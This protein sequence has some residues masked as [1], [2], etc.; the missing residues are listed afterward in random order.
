MGVPASSSC[1]AI[2]MICDIQKTENRPK[3]RIPLQWGST[4]SG[5]SVFC[6]SDIF[7]GQDSIE[8]EKFLIQT[9]FMSLS[10]QNKMNH[11]LVALATENETC[12]AIFEHWEE[13]R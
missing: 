3:G 12:T 4:G 10:A 1:M 7:P 8:F 5:A 11:D 6:V 2:V 9:L 13:F